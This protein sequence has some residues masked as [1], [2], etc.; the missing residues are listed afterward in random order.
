M[1]KKL[2]KLMAKAGGKK[3]S[4]SEMKAKLKVLGDIAKMASDGLGSNLAE[5][6]KR[7]VTVAAN[8]N[9]GL[10]KGLDKAKEVLDQQDDMEEDEEEKEE[11]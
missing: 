1:S 8:D 3:L 11:E 2:E 10:K 7:K 9:E 4:E 6:M 5:G